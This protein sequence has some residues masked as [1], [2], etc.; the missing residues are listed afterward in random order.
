MAANSNNP[1]ASAQA[2]VAACHCPRLFCG[3]APRWITALA[4]SASLLATVPLQAQ[5]SPAHGP[6]AADA[7]MPMADF[8][9]LLRQIAPAVEQGAKVYLGAYQLQCGRA[10]GAAELRHALAREGGDPVLLGLIRAAQQQDSAARLHL[11]PQIQCTADA[12]NPR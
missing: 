5:T 7:E 8:L 6:I 3:A 11:I 1:P 4:A 2:H 9:A 10:L 12:E